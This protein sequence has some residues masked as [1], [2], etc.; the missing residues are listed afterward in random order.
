MKGMKHSLALNHG[1]LD[2]RIGLLYSLLMLSLIIFSS[3]CKSMISH[4][5]ILLIGKMLMILL[6]YTLVI[7]A[8]QEII[9]SSLEQDQI[10]LYMI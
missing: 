5:S 7:K 8:I 1:G 3:I 9:G 2:M 4:N 10:L 6:Q